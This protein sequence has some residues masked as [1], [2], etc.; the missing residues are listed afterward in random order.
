MRAPSPGRWSC[1]ILAVGVLAASGLAAHADTLPDPGDGGKADDAVRRAILSAA[2]APRTTF[3][4]RE[5]LLGLGGKLE[6]HIVAN[7]GHENPKLGSFSFFETYT[8]P[9]DAGKVQEGELFL[10]YFS[11]TQG[12]TLVVQHQFR[13]GDL[14]M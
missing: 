7:R 1:L 2:Q 13:K 9:T 12:D 11:A 14:M 4:V 5:R 3:E 6:T 8:G 10:G